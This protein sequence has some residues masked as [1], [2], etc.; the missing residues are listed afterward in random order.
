MRI[1]LEDDFKPAEINIVPLIDVI[2]SILV[3]FIIASLVLTR[4]ESLDVDLPSASNSVAQTRPDVTV[5]ITN[6]GQIAVNQEIVALAD[7]PAK[8]ESILSEDTTPENENLNRL[9]LIT[10]DL[11][12]THGRFVEVSDALRTISTFDITFGIA[13][14]NGSAEG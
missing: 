8:V 12:I 7:L 13:T 3:F 9:V 2:F 14:Q 11:A 6:D 5:S 4:T 10:A 1:L